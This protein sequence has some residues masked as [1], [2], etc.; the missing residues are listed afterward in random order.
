MNETPSRKRRQM[1]TQPE[2]S[3][4]GESSD[5]DHHQTKATVRPANNNPKKRKGKKVAKVGDLV[6]ASP[7]IFDDKTGSFSKM[8]PER[9][10]GA[11]ESIE[12]LQSSILLEHEQEI[13]EV[14][15]EIGCDWRSI[16]NPWIP[17]RYTQKDKLQLLLRIIPDPWS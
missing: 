3:I 2:T 13:D 4:S 1:I 10:F 7:T 6:S 17:L 15:L 11:V 8:Y 9:C 12:S 14:Q 16:A 5:D